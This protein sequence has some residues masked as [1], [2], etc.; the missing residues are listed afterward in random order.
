MPHH[1]LP[2]PAAWSRFATCINYN[3]RNTVNVNVNSLHLID[4]RGVKAVF[5]QSDKLTARV[6]VCQVP[7]YRKRHTHELENMRHASPSFIL[8]LHTCPP[9]YFSL[10]LL[11]VFSA[12]AFCLIF[13]MSCAQRRM[14]SCGNARAEPSHD[15]RVVTSGLVTKVGPGAEPSRVSRAWSQA[16]RGRTVFSGSSLLNL[17]YNEYNI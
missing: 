17:K 3:T 10:Y 5:T 6:P 9:L 11:F 7:L 1:R 12:K 15:A 14:Q 2:A 4:V 13:R 8:L 16:A